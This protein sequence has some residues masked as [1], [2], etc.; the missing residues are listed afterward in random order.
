MEAKEKREKQ[1]QQNNV[2]DKHFTDGV[3]VWG[4]GGGER[5][6]N[7]VQR[8]NV[9]VIRGSYSAAVIVLE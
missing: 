6:S 5:L 3:C 1:Q 8:L 9:L 2:T 4:G 7:P